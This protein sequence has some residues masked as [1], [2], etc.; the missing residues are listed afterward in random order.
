MLTAACGYALLFGLRRVVPGDVGTWIFGYIALFAFGTFAS[1]LAASN[2]PR[3][4]R[5]LQPLPWTIAFVVCAALF[6]ITM[7]K[8][9]Q[10]YQVYCHLFHLPLIP[11]AVTGGGYDDE[12]YFLEDF[13]MGMVATTLL[14][15]AS[16]PGRNWLRDALSWKPLVVVGAFAYSIY[17]LHAPLLQVIWQYGILPLHVGWRAQFLLLAVIGTPLLVGLSYIFFLV[18]EKPWLV[19]RPNESMRQI[20]QDAAVSPAP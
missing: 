13:E 7:A 9:P 17:L 12:L 14:V 3:W 10:I 15:L 4:R 16:C 1:V 18:C 8:A 5:F 20:A 6:K 11:G 19:H 2:E